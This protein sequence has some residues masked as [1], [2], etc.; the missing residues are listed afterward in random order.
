MPK[1]IWNETV[2]AESDTTKLVE[3][4]HYFPREAINEEYFKPSDAT[5]FCGWKGTANYYDLEVDGKVNQQ[6]AWYYAE[7][8]SDAEAYSRHDCV[9]GKG[10]RSRSSPLKQ[11]YPSAARVRP[12]NPLSRSFE[13]GR[14]NRLKAMKVFTPLR[15]HVAIVFQHG[16][17]V[18]VIVGV[19]PF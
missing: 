8:K 14:L 17:T 3:G 6:A 4:N 9:F 19:V 2:V 10:S 12:I 1:A 18:F 5:T 15:A 7:P 11:H 16:R 13:P